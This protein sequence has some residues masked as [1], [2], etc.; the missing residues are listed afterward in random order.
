MACY[1]TRKQN[2]TTY[3][4]E[5]TSFR[6]EKGKPDN[7]KIVIGK[8]DNFT[9]QIVL[10]KKY[11][12][13]LLEHNIDIQD[14]IHILEEK[15]NI[16]N[17]KTFNNISYSNINIARNLL[18]ENVDEISQVFS[19]ED[20]NSEKKLFTEKDVSESVSINFGS[21]YLLEQLCKQIGLYQLIWDVFPLFATE[22]LSL[23]Y[24]LVS[25]KE[26]LSYCE[27]WIEDNLENVDVTKLCSQEISI[28]LQKI[29]EAQKCTFY[30]KW[31][32]LRNEQEY[33]ALDITSISS[34]SELIEDIEWGRNKEKDDLPQL[35]LCLLFGEKSGVPIYCTHFSGSITDVVTLKATLD[36]IS[37]LHD[38]EY[39]IVMD[40]GFYSAGNVDYILNNFSNFKFLLSVPMKPKFTK[41][42]SNMA[43]NLSD[44]KYKI[45]SNGQMIH[46][47]CERFKWNDKTLLAYFF[48][49]KERFAD[50]ENDLYKILYQIKDEAEHNIKKLYDKKEYKKYFSVIKRRNFIKSGKY[51]IQIKHNVVSNQLK[52]IGKMI[53]IGNDNDITVKDA[54]EIYRAK[55]VVEKGF[56]RFKSSL[57]MRRLRVHSSERQSNKEFVCFLAQI[58]ISYLDKKMSDNKLYNKLSLHKLILRFKSLKMKIIKDSRILNPL[59]KFQKDIFSLFDIE[60]PNKNSNL[61]LFKNKNT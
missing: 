6:N 57:D 16:K 19:D 48:L 9:G 13:Y 12:T 56:Q 29:S 32:D 14:T 38:K 40:K 34:Y 8:V 51:T 21:S 33:I 7:K 41:L 42:F 25:V 52:N 27:E 46:G 37:A 53:I 17:D 44:N 50:K 26:P 24:Y 36:Q 22:L 15:L 61:L 2:N 45:L 35:N 58:L 59:S 5:S 60:I 11:M 10:N 49:N 1:V 23:I 28:L 18:N 47:K 3:I 30:H 55:D 31:I 43:D 54:I 20:Q 4:C 39:K